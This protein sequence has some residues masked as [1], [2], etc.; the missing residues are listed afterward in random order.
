MTL[1]LNS[2][3]IKDC[4]QFNKELIP[5]IED[6]FKSL[7]LGKTVMPPILRVDIEK[8]HGESDVKAAYI[9][10]L[11]SFAVKV[12]SGFFNNP[13]LG[14]SSSNGLMILLDSQTGIIKSV[15]LDKGYLTDVRTAIAGAIASKYLSNPKSSTVAIIGAGIQAR[16]QLEALSL[17]RSIK[18]VKV[19][20]RDI[21]KA[22]EYIENLS[23]KYD[24]KFQV[25]DNT[26]DLVKDTD[27]LI[28]T[29][30]SKNPLIKFDSLP[31]GIHI[32]AMGSDAEEKN[33]LDPEIIKNCDAYV[34][35][36]QGQTMILGELNHAVKNNL[37]KND[38]I[39]NDLGKIIINPELG[40][41]N[42]DDIT[43]ADLTGTGVQDTAIARYAYAIANKKE[44]G[45][46][47]E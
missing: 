15:L 38:T 30:P 21:N 33:E 24:F 43:V 9:E 45:T 22:N 35:D 47:V 16:M 1:I 3:E 40:R 39:F 11:D 25:F 18:N 8:Y 41:N 34:P 27:I 26:H 20:S 5:I 36:N 2:T 44:L 31:K 4:V 6:A 19:W 28:T 46:I 12:A 17:V 42:I 10:G 32:T 37:I 29:T 7:S 14:L 23:K 13:K